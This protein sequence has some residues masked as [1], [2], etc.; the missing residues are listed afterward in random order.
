MTA[1]FPRSN[2]T[3]SWIHAG[4][5]AICSCSAL[6]SP[7]RRGY[8]S[9]GFFRGRIDRILEPPYVNI[10]LL[11]STNVVF[12]APLED[13]Y[14]STQQRDVRGCS[15]VVPSCSPLGFIHNNGRLNGSPH[16]FLPDARSGQR[17]TP[18]ETPQGTGSGYGLDIFGSRIC[19]GYDYPPGRSRFH[20]RR[21]CPMFP[22]RARCLIVRLANLFEALH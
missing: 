5:R 20:D 14:S 19:V 22:V 18:Q 7:S 3:L 8:N 1:L 10:Y 12:V 21:L 17:Y 16:Q 4:S 2:V 15:P 11:S 13:R 9:V 6:H